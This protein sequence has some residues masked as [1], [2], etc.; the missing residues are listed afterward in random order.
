MKINEGSLRYLW[1]REEKHEQISKKK[2]KK[3]KCG[4]K[5]LKILQLKTYLTWK[6]NNYPSPGSTKN[7]IQNKTMEEYAEA[8]IN[9]IDKN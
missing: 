7:S 5:Y 6:E 1:G 8:Y 2:K 3:K 4:R 9:Q